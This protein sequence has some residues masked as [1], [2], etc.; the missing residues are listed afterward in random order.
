MKFTSYPLFAFTLLVFL[1][2]FFCQ[3]AID[4]AFKSISIVLI[5]HL[6][7]KNFYKLKSLVHNWLDW[8]VMCVHFGLSPFLLHLSHPLQFSMYR[9]W[10]SMHWTV[11]NAPSVYPYIKSSTCNWWSRQFL[12][13]PI[14]NLI[15]WHF[16]HQQEVSPKC[17]IHV[18]LN[19]TWHVSTCANFDRPTR[20]MVLSTLHRAFEHD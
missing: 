16:S 15:E 19:T 11:S 12:N 13:P 8:I 18:K 14:C 9:L 5:K 17:M 1:F 10:F 2:L 4:Y 6:F 20:E 7:I 3:F